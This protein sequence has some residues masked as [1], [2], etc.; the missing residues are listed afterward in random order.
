VS[1]RPRLHPAD[2]ADNRVHAAVD[3]LFIDSAEYAKHTRKILAAQ[4]KL[5]QLASDDAWIAYLEIEQAVN[6]RVS[7]MVALIARWA[8]NEG[9]RHRGLR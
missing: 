6:A 7:M 5:Q 4:D 8:F 2:L 1:R 3:G 9:R